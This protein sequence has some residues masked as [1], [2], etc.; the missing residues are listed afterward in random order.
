VPERETLAAKDYCL[1]AERWQVDPS[2]MRRV[3]VSAEDFQHET[4]RDV[5]L[6]SGWRSRREQTSLGRAGRPAAPDHLSTHRSCP[7]TGVDVSLGP[8]PTSTMKL[9]WGRIVVLNGLRWGGGAAYPTI[10]GSL[11]TGSMWTRGL[12]ELAP[13]SLLLCT[14]S[15][16]D[17]SRGGGTLSGCPVPHLT[18]M[19]SNRQGRLSTHRSTPELDGHE[20]GDLGHPRR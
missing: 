7:A 20:V 13:N 16:D 4:G 14:G 19:P 10:S 9:I 17:S 6:I 15:P 12:A 1:L 5:Q 2:V 8:S 3:I 11:P 18:T